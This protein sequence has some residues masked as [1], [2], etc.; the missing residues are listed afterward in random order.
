MRIKKSILAGSAAMLIASS[1]SAEIASSA[2]AETV[3]PQLIIHLHKAGHAYLIDPDT[4]KVTADIKT[5]KGGTLGSATPDGK[6]IY[7]GA[8]A[9]GED[10]VTVLD[11]ASKK[12]IATI[13]T[14]S[15]PK[16]PQA[17][18]DGKM[19]VVN[20][21]GLDNGK[22]RVSF[23]D[24]A[25]NEVAKNVELKVGNDNPK[26]PTS[27]HN[28]WSLDSRYVYTVDRVDN[29]L[30]IIDTH[31]WSVMNHDVESK[32]HYPVPSPDGKEL[33]LVLEGKDRDNRPGIRVY[34]LTKPGFPKK[35]SMDMPLIGED[36]IEGHHGNFTQDGK[37]FM[38][39][40]RGGGNN[41]A[42]R[43]VAFFDV[44]TKQLVRRLTTASRGIGHAYNSP[45]GRYAII[46]NYGNN[47]VS[48]VNTHTL[49]PVKDFTIGKGRMGHAAF[50]KDGRYAYISNTGDGNLHKLDMWNMKLIAEIKTGN[51]TG[52]GQVLNVWNNI[53]EELPR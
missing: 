3:W 25:T 31:D 5:G 15:R 43:E 6:R 13:K 49:N 20:H 47:T 39:L 52:G 45:D 46:T 33:W 2:S 34:D 7:V 50:T 10:T 41:K 29:Q 17:S 44:K 12:A 4:D 48:I 21:W 27:M 51:Q 30:A 24:T 14:G 35:N 42:G 18:P 23:I 8:A 37:H 16:H 9:V 26:G 38:M 1:A 19:V 28:S 11:L 32:P 40:N 36:A 22:L 53:F